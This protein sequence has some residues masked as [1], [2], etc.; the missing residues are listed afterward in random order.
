MIEACFSLQIPDINIWK[1]SIEVGGSFGIRLKGK[2]HLSRVVNNEVELNH[3]LSSEL[4]VFRL[5]PL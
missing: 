1:Q 2:D 5:N 3:M 4:I